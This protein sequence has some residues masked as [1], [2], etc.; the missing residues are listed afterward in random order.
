MSAAGVFAALTRQQM[1]E[2]MIPSMVWSGLMWLTVGAWF[3]RDSY[4]RKAGRFLIGMG[5]L[6][7]SVGVLAWRVLL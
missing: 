2:G 7:C 6:S 3:V 1:M 5:V 4:S